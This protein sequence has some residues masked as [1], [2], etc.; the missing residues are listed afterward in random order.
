[1]PT[2][3]LQAVKTELEKD[4]DKHECFKAASLEDIRLKCGGRSRLRG[5]GIQ[6]TNTVISDWVMKPSKGSF[7]QL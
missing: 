4:N 5:T 1:M 3:A 2:I 6:V 7:Y